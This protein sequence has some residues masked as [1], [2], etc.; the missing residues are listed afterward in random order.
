MEEL[1]KRVD[2]MNDLVIYGQ[3]PA[4]R[5]PLPRVWSLGSRMFQNE[6]PNSVSVPGA[7]LQ[8]CVILQKQLHFSSTSSFLISK[9]GDK[10]LPNVLLHWAAMR[11][12]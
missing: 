12:Q 10:V 9:D 6:I 8:V 7:G 11:I 1:E 2:R 5:A 4:L 3:L